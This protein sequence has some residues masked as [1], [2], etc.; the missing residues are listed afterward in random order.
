MNDDWEATNRPAGP[1]P[2]TITRAALILVILFC[3]MALL[4]LLVAYAAVNDGDLDPTFDGDG[5]VVISFT[6]QADIA[7]SIEVQDDGKILLVGRSQQ[8]IAIFYDV[9]VA[10][11]NP[12]GSPDLSFGAGG[13]VT[14]GV[15]STATGWDVVVQPDEKIVIAGTVNEGQPGAAF[16]VIRY[17]PNGSLDSAWATGGIGQYDIGPQ[18]ELATSIV[19]LNDGSFLVA[20]GV[21]RGLGQADYA[22]I[23]L[24]EGGDL[25]TGWGNNGVL[26][27][28]LGSNGLA[29]DM[30]L[31]DETH[32]VLAGF[33][34]YGNATSDMAMLHL[35]PQTAELI[36]TIGVS[37]VVTADVGQI[38]FAYD[39]EVR[40]DG[41]VAAAGL[42]FPTVTEPPAMALSVHQ[43]D[44]SPDLTFNGTGHISATVGAYQS[45][46]NGLIWQADGKLIAG[47]T[48]FSSQTGPGVFAMA[49]FLPNGGLDNT[50]GAG[51]IVFTDFGAGTTNELRDL[52]RQADG[53]LLAGG[54]M[55]L[56]S[57]FA[58]V[59]F[60]IARYEIGAGPP[61][62]TATPTPTP[63][64]SFIAGQYLPLIIKQ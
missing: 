48:A 54:G 38:D 27:K 22:V 41:S 59:E 56:P 19:A 14:T 62:P 4:S 13:M 3:A 24:D 47:G 42:T 64:P 45:V 25:E 55:A 60:A 16:M 34:D 11:L 52:A 18:G 44:G 30:E 15:G 26:T 49:R 21:D 33:V 6:V 50:F 10:R 32:A 7:E 17:L 35:N 28:T 40:P 46:A 8:D 20:G 31:V 9:A 43:A 5:R 23:R 51:G 53:K 12:D 58:D 37:G 36:T 57:S 29:F 1:V 2:R 63:D 61:P 39:I